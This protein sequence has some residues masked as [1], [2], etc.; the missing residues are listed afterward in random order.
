MSC[1]MKIL[2]WSESLAIALSHQPL[3]VVFFLRACCDENLGS[4]ELAVQAICSAWA[5]LDLFMGSYVLAMLVS[6]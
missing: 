4:Y 3:R 5:I 1:G 2:A 6:W